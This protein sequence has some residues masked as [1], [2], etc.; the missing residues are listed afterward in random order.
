MAGVEFN[1]DGKRLASCGWDGTVRLWDAVTGAALQTLKG[2]SNEV[3]SI[4]FS[5]DGKLVASSLYDTTIRL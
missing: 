4:A 5:S 2:H 3:T 1:P